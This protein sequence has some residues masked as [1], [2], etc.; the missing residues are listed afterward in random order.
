[1][2][3][4]IE[5]LI[6]PCSCDDGGSCAARSKDDLNKSRHGIL[7]HEVVRKGSQRKLEGRSRPLGLMLGHCIA[8]M[9]IEYF[10]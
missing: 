8:R 6:R 3:R 7:R 9:L 5:V 10:D 4:P 2:L 1:M